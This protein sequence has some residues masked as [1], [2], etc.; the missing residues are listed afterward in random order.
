[1]S[2]KLIAMRHAMADKGIDA[3]IIP[4]SDAHQ[5]EYIADYWRTRHW[6]S[7]FTG[8]NG[9]IAV[10]EKAA[11]LW[12]DGR[13][14]IQAEKQLA[15]SGI[16][17][18]KMNEPNV[19][20]YS[21][22]LADNLPQ[23]AKVGF[24]GRVLSVAELGV[25]KR[26]F[27]HKKISFHYDDDI[28]GALWKDRPPLPAA[29]AFAHDIKF[30]GKYTMDKLAEVRAKM[31]KRRVD[32]YLTAA[33][34]EIAWLANIRGNDIA[35]TPVVYAYLL[36]AMDNAWLFIDEKKISFPLDLT[37]CPYEDIF[38]HLEK[39]SGSLLYQPDAISVKLFNAIP[40]TAKPVKGQSIIAGL[41]AVKNETEIKNF[42]NA[43]IKEGV[44]MVRF[45]KWLDESDVSNIDEIEVQN[46]I[47]DLRKTG[48]HSL[49]DSFTSIAAYGENAALMHYSPAPKN[50]SK[51]RPE[52]FLLVDT[53]GQYLDGTTDITRTISLGDI[54]KEMRRDFTLVL[55]GHIALASAKFLQGASGVHLDVLARQYIWEAGM[56]YKS[57]TG[58][59]LGFCLGVHE[60]PQNISMRVK[61][62]KLLPGMICTNEPGIYKE[63]RFGIR[64][65]NVLLVKELERNE[66]GTFLGFE[67]ISYC[68][69]DTKAIDMSLL[70]AKEMEYLNEYHQLVYEKLSP[71][72]SQE[73][74]DWLED[75]IKSGLCP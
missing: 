70:T 8:S 68:P 71:L 75:K 46:K 36:V 60:G 1:M 24:D 62:Q 73:E 18:F 38:G 2:E 37:I 17:L 41:K 5:S 48:E 13:Y 32:L 45:L 19:P 39:V 26:D 51:L 42:R 25:L 63:G 56:D 59:G 16:K 67:V 72:L 58:H 40:K 47:S 50:C 31:K 61:E 74:R 3:Y 29:P 66:H 34:D 10:T 52:G 23:N 57:G 15:G 4:G 14:F 30:T 35:N 21:K 53:G 27:A 55:K 11:G 6:L 20:T 65:E 12:T 44:V 43:F 69:I 28:A 22:W 33:L 9:L 54:T 7:G 49:G 64:T